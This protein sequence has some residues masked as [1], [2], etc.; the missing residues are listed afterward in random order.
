MNQKNGISTRFMFMDPDGN[1]LK[2]FNEAVTAS[3]RLLG[4]WWKGIDGAS[5]P[6]LSDGDVKNLSS[7][8]D[9]HPEPSLL[10][11]PYTKLGPC[12]K[13]LFGS[14]RFNKHNMMNVHPTPFLPAVVASLFT[15][16]Q[17]PNN[18]SP[19]TSPA[20]T[21]LEEECISQLAD[22]LGF[23]EENGAVKCGG[24]ILSCGSLSNLTALM[25]AREKTYSKHYR[26]QS[27]EGLG[28]FGLPRGIIVTSKSAHYSIQKAARILGLGE[29][30]VFEVPVADENEIAEFEKSGTPLKLKPTKEAYAEAFE[31]IEK[32]THGANSEGQLIISAVSTLGTISTGTIEPVQRLVDLRKE[33]GFHLHVDAAIGGLAL[34]LSEVKCKAAGVEQAD[35]VTMDPHKLG[36][37]HY[38]CSAVIFRKK[39]DLDVISTDA[40]YVDSS[41]S[42]IE[43]SRPGSG[44]AGLWVALKTLGSEG[45]NRIIGECIDLTRKLADHLVDVGFQVLH[46]VD[47]NT[48]CFSIGYD[49]KTRKKLNRMTSDSHARLVADGEY[50]LAKVEDLSGVM[51]RDRPWHSSSERVKVTG[52]KAW[53]MN[54]YTTESDLESLVNRLHEKK[55]ELS[56]S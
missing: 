4:L 34:G 54:P 51:V 22:L 2:P 10:K 12:I 6:L 9:E 32:G 24:N 35:S 42:T 29:G 33:Y 47:L 15:M 37:L 27:S 17:N 25:V 31:R 3:I 5:P 8:F 38:P 40:P 43:G 48:L 28:L 14:V 18:L 52:I 55:K 46:E 36:F 13:A 21:L 50:L 30:G 16:L 49:G 44:V 56:I 19:A 53:I 11:E 45:Y 41:A 20:T 26:G 23:H 7:S 39:S 1:N